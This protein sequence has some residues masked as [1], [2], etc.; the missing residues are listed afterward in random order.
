M[1]I[2]LYW[3]SGSTPAWRVQLALAVKGLPYTSH[4]LSF[5]ARETRTPEFLAINPR[6]KVPALRDGDVV[7]NESIAILAYLDR[8]YPEH[9]LFGATPAEA[10]KVWRMVMEFESHG[11]P[12]ISAV[13]RPLLFGT[14]E[15]DSG[16]V[17]EGLPALHTE[18]DLL[19]ERV[20]TGTMVGDTV[21]AADIVWF[22][23][24][25]QLVRAATRP[26][27]A[28][29]DLGVWPLSARWPAIAAWARRIE[30][31][32][33]YDA[34]RPPHWAEGEHPSPARIG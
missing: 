29:F 20:A 16:K 34:T 9:P 8:A 12:T 30:A 24:L 31:I 26:A 33:G 25:Q 28:G 19:A 10:A 18:L 15:A 27:A 6:G 7:V 23:G 32:E 1:S 17:R 11:N 21:S 4:L 13:A 5:S 3:G 14:W 22:C 2:E